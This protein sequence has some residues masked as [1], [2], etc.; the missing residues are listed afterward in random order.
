ME[1]TALVAR[2]D[3]SKSISLDEK[4]YGVSLLDRTIR[5]ANKAGAK[6]IIVPKEVKDRPK[7]RRNPIV[8]LASKEQAPKFVFSTNKIYTNGLLEKGMSPEES[9]QFTINSKNDLQTVKKELFKLCRKNGNFVLD[10][11]WFDWT[12][13]NL[14]KLMSPLNITPN[15][16]TF[17]GLLVAITSCVF[18]SFGTAVSVA[19]GGILVHVGFILDS[20][21]GR[22]ARL[23]GLSSKFGAFFDGLLDSA[24]SNLWMLGITLALYAQGAGLIYI[25][26]ALSAIMG[27][28]LTLYAYS[29][30]NEEVEISSVNNDG[31]SIQTLFA[32][33]FRFITYYEVRLFL[34]LIFALINRLDILVIFF[35]IIFNLRWIGL[36]LYKWLKQR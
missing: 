33:L 2:I 24:E 34:I 12:G 35:A 36:V 20:T 11:L 15:I 4:I 9:V 7:Y 8:G 29:T 21:D 19:V 27:D 30:N 10:T 26:A 3:V 18:F 14:A 17:L 28:N 25:I 5:S 22:L 6:K 1:K 31:F 32:K 23:K 13:S 16:V